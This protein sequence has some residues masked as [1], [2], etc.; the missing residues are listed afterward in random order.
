VEAAIYIPAMA[1]INWL[2]G[3][4]FGDSL[5]SNRPAWMKAANWLMS[6]VA[7]GAYFAVLLYFV[8][9]PPVSEYVLAL[10]FL[11]G[12]W[13]AAGDN[14][15]FHKRVMFV[16][17]NGKRSDLLLYLDYKY[18]LWI[19]GGRD[20][21]I[22]NPRLA[23]MRYGTYAGIAFATPF[24]AALLYLEITR[25]VCPLGLLALIPPFSY[26]LIYG[27]MN[28]LPNPDKQGETVGRTAYGLML[29]LSAYILS[30]YSELC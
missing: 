28:I 27:A 16:C 23:A 19:A 8:I 14:L 9:T 7:C 24:A 25:G 20:L 6:D 4:A 11:C 1:L 13:Y 5:G 18:E 21:I 2:K 26:G 22:D 12:A 30:L 29:G 10:L 17:W 3:F 15:I